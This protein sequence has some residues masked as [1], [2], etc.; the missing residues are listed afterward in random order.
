MRSESRGERLDERG[1]H[2]DLPVRLEVGPGDIADAVEDLGRRSRP[3]RE[4]PHHSDQHELRAED[5][6]PIAVIN[7]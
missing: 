2:L 4:K 6:G 1:V 3:V 5:P 7:P